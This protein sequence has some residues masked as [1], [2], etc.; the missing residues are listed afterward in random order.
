MNQKQKLITELIPLLKEKG[1]K[2][3]KHVWYKENSDLIILFNIQHSNYSKEEYYIILG[4]SIKA[5]EKNK[6]LCLNCH[7][8]QEVPCKNEK[9]EF[10]SATTL[11]SILGLWEDWYGNL[12]S[13]RRKAIEGKLPICSRGDAITFLTTFI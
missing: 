11:I 9:D 7:I 2:K 4:I 6:K 13:L 1:Y 12:T 10:L 3:E 5:L 8:S